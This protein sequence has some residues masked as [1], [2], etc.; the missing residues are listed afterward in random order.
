MNNSNKDYFFS[1]ALLEEIKQKDPMEALAAIG[2]SKSSP[3]RSAGEIRDYCPIHGGDT[4]KSLAIRHDSGAFLCHNGECEAKGGD[5]IELYQQSKKCDFSTAVQDLASYFGMAVEHGVT[6]DKII[7]GNSDFRRENSVQ[8][9]NEENE[10]IKLEKSRVI[11]ADIL[12]RSANEGSCRY[13]ERKGV[14]APAGVRYGKD[15]KGNSAA[16]VPYHDVEGVLQAV[17]FINENPAP[18]KFFAKDT[19]SRGAFF[20]FGLITEVSIVNLCEGIA[21][22]ASAWQSQNKAV[23]TLSCG[24][25][26]NISNVVTE[27]KKNI[28]RCSL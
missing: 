7:Q 13:F 26:S 23:T 24:S 4:Q 25:S 27:L 19:T 17:Q 14:E 11:A 10:K 8:K 16:I 21:T 12:S 6:N 3:H 28:R 20:A 22:A 9:K 18:N 15:E 5:V 2:Y 1:R